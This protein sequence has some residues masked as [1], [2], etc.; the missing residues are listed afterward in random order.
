MPF[1]GPSR[2]VS[3]GTQAC[4]DTLLYAIILVT[5]MIVTIIIVTTV[6]DNNNSSNK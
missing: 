6:L 3:C 2:V 4:M 1:T 5:I